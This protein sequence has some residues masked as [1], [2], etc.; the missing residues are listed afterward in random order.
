MAGEMTLSLRV[1]I[2]PE[3]ELLAPLVPPGSQKETT[4][5]RRF[6]GGGCRAGLSPRA[7]HEAGMHLEQ[8]NP[9]GAVT[10]HFLDGCGKETE[11]QELRTEEAVQRGLSCLWYP[12][13]GKSL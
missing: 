8:S 6:K 4:C 12:V 11:L 3:A 1:S 5:L 9:W 7:S 13:R 2:E 10:C